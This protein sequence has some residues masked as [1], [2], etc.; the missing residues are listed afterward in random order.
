M[1]TGANIDEGA[2]FSITLP[3]DSGRYASFTLPMPIE[4]ARLDD[5][6]IDLTDVNIAALIALIEGGQILVSDGE[7]ADTVISGRLD[8]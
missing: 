7:E 1:D 2:T 5:G 3:G 8:T 4:A 6:R